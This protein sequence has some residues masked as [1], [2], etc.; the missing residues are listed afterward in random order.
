M[1]ETKKIKN[2]TEGPLFKNIIFFAIPLM[3]TSVLQ[4][5]FNTADTIV[6]GRWGGA[7]P[8]ECEA[9]LAAVGSCGSL[10][11][12][13]TLLFA[14]IS[15]GAGVSIAQDIGAKDY[16]G[17]SKTV[18]TSVFF[19]LVSSIFVTFVGLFFARPLLIL[20]GTEASVLDQ[21]VPYIVAYFCGMPAKMLYNYCAAILRSAG[22]TVRPMKYLVAG[23]IVNVGL[24]LIMVLVFKLGAVGVGVATA[25]SYWISCALIVIHMMR[26]TDSPYHLEIKKIGPNKEKLKKILRIGIPAGIQGTIFSVSHVLIQSSVNSLGSAVVAGNAAAANLDGYAYQPMASF[27]Q[28]AVTFVGQHKGAKKYKR[29][30]KCIVYCMICATVTGLILGWAMIAFGHALLSLYIPG[31]AAAISAGLARQH[32]YTSLCFILGLMEVGSGVVRGLGH[33]TASMITALLGSVAFRVLWIIFIF[34]LAPSLTLLMCSFPIS[35]VLTAVTHYIVSIVVIKKEVRNLAISESA[36]K[37]AVIA[38]NK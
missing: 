33:S 27:Y 28:A 13:L 3:I 11:N 38:S 26:A 31:N 16:D 37:A 22:Q 2:F 1:T 18:H 12:L 8:E 7:T 4:L 24:N 32:V 30:K 29:M 19:S 25:A 23:G 35:W 9:A 20:M 21:A 15:L 10:I 36:E 34:P 6:V 17:I 14:N 5:L